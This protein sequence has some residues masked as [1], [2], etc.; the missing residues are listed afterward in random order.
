M[1]YDLFC[2]H[3]P[4]RL[5]FSSHG[6]PHIVGL[7]TPHSLDCLQ[8]HSL[9]FQRLTLVL[10]RPFLPT[11]HSGLLQKHFFTSC[12]QTTL[13]S[14][15]TCPSKSRVCHCDHLMPRSRVS[16]TT[17]PGRTSHL[18]PCLFFLHAFCCYPFHLLI[19]TPS[20]Q[21]SVATVDKSSSPPRK[22][23]TR[24]IRSCLPPLQS[25]SSTSAFL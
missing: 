22:E 23:I 21:K 20:A 3:P 24:W 15:A 13:M 1:S 10:C 14:T 18:S 25:A 6:G 7:L 19:H 4:S 16:R 9:S 11:D 2:T 5:A 8:S 12:G 17:A